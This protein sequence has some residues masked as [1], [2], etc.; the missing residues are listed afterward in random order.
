[1]KKRFSNMSGVRYLSSLDM[2]C[3]QSECPLVT[4]TGIPIHW[5]AAHLTLDGARLVVKRMFREGLPMQ[6]AH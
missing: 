1:M 6:I 3:K 5:D 4:N 2:F